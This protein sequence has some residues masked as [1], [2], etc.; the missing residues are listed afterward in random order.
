MCDIAKSFMSAHRVFFDTNVLL[1]MHGG[2]PAKRQRAQELY[3][4]Y[5]PGG[6]LV[7]STQVVQEFYAAGSRRFAM[8]RPELRAATNA[9]LDWPLV[10]IGPIHIAAAI[11]RRG[12]PIHRRS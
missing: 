7:L 10:V 2:D 6:R 9:L 5:A 8:P 4:E 3:R 12:N 11:G 1:Y